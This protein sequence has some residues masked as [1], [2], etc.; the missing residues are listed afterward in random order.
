MYGDLELDARCN[1][2]EHEL[3]LFSI[4]LLR[5]DMAKVFWREGSV[6]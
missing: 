2:P 6:S 1:N 4:L 5:T 3:F